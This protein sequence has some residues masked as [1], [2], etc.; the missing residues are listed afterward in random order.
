[1]R[2]ADTFKANPH[3]WVKNPEPI[4]S[5]L[6]AFTRHQFIITDFF[7]GG[8]TVPDV[9]KMLG[10]HWLAF[11][12]DPAIA[13]TARERVRNTQPPLPHCQPE[14]MRLDNAT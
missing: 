4:I 6:Q 9:C 14:Q 7:T 12:I 5:W 2:W 13:E 1:M 3:V 8:G 10:R 11:E